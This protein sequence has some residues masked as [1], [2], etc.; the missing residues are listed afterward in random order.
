M[1]TGGSPARSP[2]K[3]RD[4]RRGAQHC[5]VDGKSMPLNVKTFANNKTGEPKQSR[6]E[7]LRLTGSLIAFDL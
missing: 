1:T 5:Q 2:P 7:T 4:D 3:A 6:N